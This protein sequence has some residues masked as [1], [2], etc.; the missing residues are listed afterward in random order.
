MEIRETL[1]NILLEKGVKAD[2]L[3][4]ET[5]LKDL[6]LDSLDIVEV[7][8]GIEEELGIEFS[9]DELADAKTIKDV[10]TLIEKKAK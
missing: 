3:N 9:T 7:M 5:P 4:E 6:G 2:Q 1:E 10:L 8:M